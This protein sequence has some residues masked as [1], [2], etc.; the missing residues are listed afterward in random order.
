MVD[1][2]LKV[3]LRHLRAV[4]SERPTGA[5]PVEFTEWRERIAASLDAL[6]RVLRFEEDRVRARAE[7]A[8]ARAQADEI[9]MPRMNAVVERWVQT[10]RRE[11]MDRALVWNQRHL[12]HALRE[13]ERFYHVHRPHQGIANTRPLNPLPP[14]IVDP[15]QIACLE[16]RRRD[17]LG[18]LLHTYEN[19]A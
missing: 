10:C 7:A 12:L 5:E 6:A 8:A 18:G 4:K 14:P 9:R 15:D 3:A 2:V 16:V 13:F 17:R 1:P 11:L 19:A